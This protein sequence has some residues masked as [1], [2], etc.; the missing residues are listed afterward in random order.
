MQVEDQR[1]S[2]KIQKSNI[3][4]PV[5]GRTTR[6]YALIFV[7]IAE[8]ILFSFLLPDTFFTLANWQVILA[9]QAALL[10]MTLGVIIPLTAGEYDFS[11]PAV[12]TVVVVIIGYTNVVIKLPIWLSIALCLAFALIVAACHIILIVRLRISSIVVTLGTATLLNGMALAIQNRSIAGVSDLLVS[13]SRTKVFGV[14]SYFWWGLLLTA[15]VWYTLHYTPFGRYLFFTGASREV[16]R[17]SGVAVDRV[18]SIA[19]LSSTLIATF[20]G[21]LSAGL[22]GGSDPRV[23]ASFLLPMFAAAFLGSTVVNP[24]RFNAWGTF[25]AVYF[26]ATGI[27]GLQLLGFSGWIENVFYGAALLIAVTVAR[28]VG[29]RQVGE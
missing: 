8:A 10:V 12:Y 23:G 25:V 13:I 1:A 28:M 4:I 2:Q 17:L 27:T 29:A 18:R 7:W 26:L 14:Q 19:L 15:L 6:R 24:G 11:M 21:I 22:L 16:A 20:A 3:S 5:L 9:G